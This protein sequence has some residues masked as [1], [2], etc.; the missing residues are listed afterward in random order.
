MSFALVEV[1]F[2]PELVDSACDLADPDI[3]NT[4]QFGK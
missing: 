4:Q 3:R 2:I 1:V